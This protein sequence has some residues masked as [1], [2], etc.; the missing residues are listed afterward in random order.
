MSLRFCGRRQL[1]SPDTY[2]SVSGWEAYHTNQQAST[3]TIPAPLAAVVNGAGAVTRVE[4]HNQRP[5][6]PRAGRATAANHGRREAPR[7]VVRGRRGLAG[8]SS[9][10]IAPESHIWTPPGLQEMFVSHD[11]P[12]I[13]LQPYIRPLME[14][15]AL[16][17][18]GGIRAPSPRAIAFHGRRSW[19]WRSSWL[20]KRRNR[21][22]GFEAPTKSSCC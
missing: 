20:R 1:S 22:A 7:R 3:L 9:Q 19:A 15:I 16:P 18:P 14:G 6:P 4:A 11:I 13:R 5:P 2:T 21:G 17:G 8:A 12:M 10:A